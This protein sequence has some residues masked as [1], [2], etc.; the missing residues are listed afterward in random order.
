MTEKPES[1]ESLLGP[2]FREPSVGTSSSCRE[3]ISVKRGLTKIQPKPTKVTSSS[4]RTGEYKNLLNNTFGKKCGLWDVNAGLIPYLSDM[5]DCEK[6][7]ELEF[8]HFEGI[9]LNNPSFDYKDTNNYNSRY[10]EHLVS[11]VFKSKEEF[12]RAGSNSICIESTIKLKQKRIIARKNY[13]RLKRRLQPRISATE[14]V[15]SDTEGENVQLPIQEPDYKDEKNY[16]LTT[17]Y[18]SQELGNKSFRQ[19]MISTAL[20]NCRYP[21]PPP[22]PNMSKEPPKVPCRPTKP[23]GCCPSP[24]P[25]MQQ[26]YGQQGFGQQGYGQQGFGQKGYGQQGYGQQG[27]GQQQAAYQNYGGQQ[28][29]GYQMAPPPMNQ[30]NPYPPYPQNGL[31]YPGGGTPQQNPQKARRTTPPPRTCGNAGTT[32]ARYPYNAK[33]Y[34]GS[35]QTNIDANRNNASGSRTP[36][37]PNGNSPRPNYSARSATNLNRSG[38]DSKTRMQPYR[39]PNPGNNS[40]QQ[41][42]SSRSPSPYSPRVDFSPYRYNSRSRTDFSPQPRSGRSYPNIPPPYGGGGGGYNQYQ[43]NAGC[44]PDPCN[45]CCCPIYLCCCP[46]PKP[47]RRKRPPRAPSFI[48]IKPTP[49]CCGP[50]VDCCCDCCCPGNCDCCC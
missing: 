12:I 9:H 20:A 33:R 48:M 39:N 44:M 8:S 28:N 16:K 18:Y 50:C 34:G 38:H 27:Y 17:H 26:G 40:Y 22:C 19:Y 3:I 29:Y 14:T 2:E 32:F 46:C 6:G 49:P 21:C 37:T 1:M 36:C 31:P 42:Y 47:K 45:P 11:R 5:T 13:F 10:S 15:K 25:Q 23:T 24:N 43:N 4:L 35:S 7:T 30:G 41:N